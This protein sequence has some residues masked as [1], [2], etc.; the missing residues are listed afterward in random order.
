MTVKHRANGEPTLKLGAI[1]ITYRNIVIMLLI[2][3]TPLG[4]PVWRMAGWVDSG[5]STAN[6]A[7]VATLDQINK[8]MAALET[9]VAR[10]S[11]TVDSV[12]AFVDGMKHTHP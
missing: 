9:S 6:N 3:L 4:K 8:R 2:S 11:A 1:D 12:S 5:D 7:T 10:L